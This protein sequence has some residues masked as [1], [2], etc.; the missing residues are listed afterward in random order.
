MLFRSPW[1]KATHSFRFMIT[2]HY[3][4]VHTVYFAFR[5]YAFSG[6][7]MDLFMYDWKPPEHWEHIFHYGSPAVPGLRI[8][9][10]SL[11]GPYS[12][13]EHTYIAGTGCIQVPLSNNAEPDNWT[14]AQRSHVGV[15]APE[16][17]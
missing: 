6:C 9:G 16:G 11:P 3:E 1:K 10:G 12:T 5:Y 17:A 4:L 13:S 15:L 8:C 2:Q 14:N 7:P